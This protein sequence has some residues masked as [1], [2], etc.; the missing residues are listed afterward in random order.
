MPRKLD[1]QIVAYL[2]EIR[3]ASLFRQKKQP[4][5]KQA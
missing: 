1:N 2:R 4:A 3:P 5:I